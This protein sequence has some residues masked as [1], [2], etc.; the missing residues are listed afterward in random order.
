M[1]VIV[2]L[3]RWFIY[4]P[5]IVGLILLIRLPLSLKVTVFYLL[6]GCLSEYVGKY[7]AV[8]YNNN[9]PVFNV[10]YL[11]HFVFLFLFFIYSKSIPTANNKL[12]FLSLI[13]LL[14]IW[15]IDNLLIHSI[16]THNYW[17]LLFFYLLILTS[18]INLLLS[19]FKNKIVFYKNS[20]FYFALG[21]LLYYT[22]LNF[23]NILTLTGGIK[24]DHLFFY[25]RPILSVILLTKYFLFTLGFLWIKKK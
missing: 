17:F 16:F 24:E 10:S 6:L 19:T 1:D 14:V 18:S 11:L 9:A 13:F 8:H 5:T 25:I 20:F 4:V 22:F 3:N 7:F 2:Y 15:C 12:Q 21:I 23:I